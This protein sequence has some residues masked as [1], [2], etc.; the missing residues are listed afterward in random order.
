MGWRGENLNGEGRRF[1]R[2][3]VIKLSAFIVTILIFLGVAMTSSI[4]GKVLGVVLLA[5]VVWSLYPRR[6]FLS[7]ILIIALLSLFEA[8]LS[9][10]EF[11]GSLF[12]AYGGSGLWIIITGFILSAAM[13]VSGLGRRLAMGIVAALGG[14]PQKVILSVAV[15]NLAISPISPSTMA[16]AFMLLPICEGLIEA[17]GVQKGRSRYAAAIMI[18]SMAANN[19]CSTGFLTATIPNPISAQYIQDFSGIRL[20]WTEWLRMALPLTIVLLAAAW[21]LCRWMF[22]PEVEK[23][24]RMMEQIREMGQRLGPLSRGEALVALLFS[25]SLLLWITEGRHGLN[26]GLI[27]LALSLVLFLPRIGV[28]RIGRFTGKIPWGSIALFA[29]SMFLARAVAHWQ[30][31]DPVAME[32]AQLLRLESLPPLLFVSVSVV[33]FMLLHVA[34]TSTTVY[35]T[36]MVPLSISLATFAGVEPQFLAMPV[37]VLTPIALIL[38][39]NTIPNI[40]FY[41]AGYFTQ[42]QMIAYGIIASLICASIVLILGMPYW[43]IIGLI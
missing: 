33:V 17:F 11:I 23:T 42:R 35:A 20:S 3:E 2:E 12:S 31:L 10:S 16:K 26:A 27:S 5:L 7:S 43:R 36:V 14:D 21:L 24:P 8:S 15:A 38:P 25:V 4:Q 37:A 13:E 40:V 28:L 19:V 30:A 41:S 32:I 39:V 1:G 18:M 29:A 6:H 9:P 34:F 22:K